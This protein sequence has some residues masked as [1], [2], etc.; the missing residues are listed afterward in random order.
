MGLVLNRKVNEAIFI[1]EN[2]KVSV[3][4]VRGSR[5]KLYIEAPKNVLILKEEL[6]DRRDEYY[7]KLF[8]G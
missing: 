1:G 6:K 3:Y 8:E 7:R 2:I 4:G 5:V